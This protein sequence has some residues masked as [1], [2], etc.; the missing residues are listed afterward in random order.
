MPSASL[1]T[2]LT[3][4][5]GQ[6]M[7]FAGLPDAQLLALAR[8]V[9]P[10]DYRK[11][12]ILFQEGDAGTGFFV[13]QTGRI[14]VF[15]LSPEG[16]EQ[17]LHVFGSGDH[18]AEVPALDGQCFPAAAAA[19][20]PT[21]VLFFPRQPFLHLLEQQ[22]ALAINLLRSFARHLRQLSHLVDTLAL[23]EVPARLAA[24]VLRLAEGQAATTVV[25]D[26]PK[27]Q[28]AAQLGTIPETLSRVFGK[29]TREGLMALDGNQVTI[30]DRR[31]LQRL[32]Q[33]HGKS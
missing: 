29:L 18:F 26:L 30:L 21:T 19:L 14:K 25:L 6:T 10:Q 23:R 31:G 27:T 13:I 24:Y 4:F 32:A 15:K 11:G 3:P 12:E 28:L 33:G 17:I 1:A 9:V 8:L 22:P 2:A 16:R 20:E 5:L 7:L